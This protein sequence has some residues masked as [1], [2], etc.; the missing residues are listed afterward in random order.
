MNADDWVELT[1]V[2]DP[3]EH[4]EDLVKLL[5]PMRVFAGADD[6]VYLFTDKDVNVQHTTVEVQ[7]R[8]I[9][10]CRHASPCPASVIMMVASFGWIIRPPQEDAAEPKLWRTAQ[11]A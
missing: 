1:E 11:E 10:S 9:C 8:W 3:V 7:G 5:G 4:M 2:F 6:R